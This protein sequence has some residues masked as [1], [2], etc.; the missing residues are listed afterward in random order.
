MNSGFDK[1]ENDSDTSGD[2]GDSKDLN[3][4]KEQIQKITKK[5]KNSSQKKNQNNLIINT[6]EMDDLKKKF[7]NALKRAEKR[8]L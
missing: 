4:S 5:E 3:V 7:E 8:K 6:N 1:I 2:K